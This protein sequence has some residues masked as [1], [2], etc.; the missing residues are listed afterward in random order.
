MIII[1]VDDCCETPFVLFFFPSSFS[2]FS[3]WTVGITLGLGAKAL[4]LILLG[5][6]SINYHSLLAL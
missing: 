3:M 2:S 5:H 4:K 1:L 6:T